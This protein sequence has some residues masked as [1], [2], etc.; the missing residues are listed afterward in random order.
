MSFMKFWHFHS[1]LACNKNSW[2]LSG[3]TAQTVMLV[4][5]VLSFAAEAWFQLNGLRGKTSRLWHKIWLRCFWRW[6][7]G[8]CCVFLS[9]HH[10]TDKNTSASFMCRLNHLQF[11]VAQCAC[12]AWILVSFCHFIILRVLQTRWISKEEK[13]E[14]SNVDELSL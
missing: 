8:C 13:D 1:C 6:V 9:P 4:H 5:S 3:I 7:C 11:L 14:I 10:W 2:T 12:S